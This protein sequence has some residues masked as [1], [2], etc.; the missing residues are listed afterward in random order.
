[1]GAGIAIDRSKSCRNNLRGAISGSKNGVRLTSARDFESGTEPD[2]VFGPRFWNVKALNDRLREQG[3]EGC[4]E[5]AQ[6]RG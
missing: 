5:V 3:S 4:K 2:P 6:K 1:M